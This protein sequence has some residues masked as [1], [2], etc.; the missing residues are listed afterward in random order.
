MLPDEVAARVTAEARRRRMPMAAVVR[1][2]VEHHL[3]HRGEVA[4][5]SFIAVGE[6]DADGSERVDQVVA[7]A[8]TRRRRQRS[9]S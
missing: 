6:G 3:D 9:A 4:G 8:V 5:L 1:E 7:A 2:A